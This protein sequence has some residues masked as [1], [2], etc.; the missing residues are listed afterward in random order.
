MIKGAYVARLDLEASHLSGVQKK[1]IGQV[2]AFGTM[3]SQ[4]DLYYPTGSSIKR[5]GE[6]IYQGSSRKWCIRFVYVVWFYVVLSRQLAG[7]DFIYIRYQR[8]SPIFLWFLAKLRRR[9]PSTVLLVEVPT[10]PYD[11]ELISRRERVLGLVDR[12]FR[13]R[14]RRY[15]DRIV[16]FSAKK[17]IFGIP[18]INTDNGIDVTV[19]SVL[20][21]HGKD[22]DAFRLLGLANL[23]FWHGYDRVI[24]GLAQYRSR[25]GTRKIGFDI[26]GTGNELARLQAEVRACGLEDDVRFWG[27]RQ[28]ADLYEIMKDC[29]I[30]ISS[31]GIH[32]VSVDTSTLKSREF[33]ASGLP[34]VLGYADRDF[35]AGLPF[36]HQ[37]PAD[38]SPVDIPALLA[39]FDRLVVDW[40]DYPSLMRAYAENHL[41]WD[42]KMRPVFESIGA[43]LTSKSLSKPAHL[44]P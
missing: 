3:P 7:V 40:P 4:V 1:V 15:V 31:I 16:T 39:F 25:G 19:Q 41:T 18:A 21:V 26:V 23:S 38:D 11:T 24:R 17:E 10:F 27:V 5:N 6:V 32:R 14:M 30:G 12:M 20:P 8:C 34:F 2:A 28:G 36:V 13:T 44:Q 9:N 43:S 37:V 33:C 22:L 29:Q 42:V 35:G